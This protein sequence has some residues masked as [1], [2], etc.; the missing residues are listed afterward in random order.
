MNFEISA[1]ARE[2]SKRRGI[3]P[4]ILESVLANP[5][6]IVDEYGGK[7]AYQ[8]KIAFER[9]KIYLVRVIVKEHAGHAVAVTVYRTSKIEKYWRI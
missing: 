7:K 1:H 9:D 8:S 3:P 4:D 2:E 6:Q 5:G